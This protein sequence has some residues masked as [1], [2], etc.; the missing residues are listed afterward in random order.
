[1]PRY[2][3][4]H[5]FWRDYRK[6]NEAQRQ[7]FRAAVEEFVEDLKVGP[8]EIRP[9]LRVKKVHGTPEVWE[10]TWADDGRA[11]FEY[12]EDSREDDPHVIWRRI[13]THDV[14]RAP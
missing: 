12:A 8:D 4:S 3:Q 7:L 1:V 2:S 11:T 6:P 5:R 9:S 13:G 10:M 14:F